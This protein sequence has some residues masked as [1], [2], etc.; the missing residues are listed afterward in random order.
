MR[1]TFGYTA[2]FLVRQRDVLI[3]SVACPI[4]L[5]AILYAVLGHVDETYTLDPV[6]LVVVED[7][8]FD[9]H[10]QFGAFVDALA[11]GD[12]ALLAPVAAASVDEARATMADGSFYGY[13]TLTADGTP[14]WFADS[15]HYGDPDD[16]APSVA[17]LILDRYVQQAGLAGAIAATNPAAFQDPAVLE[18]LAGGADLTQQVVVTANPPSDSVRY[19]YTLLGY[20]AFM[21]TYYALV[22]IT[23]TRA[24]QGSLGA[25]RT[26][27]GL[28]QV[29]TLVP[30]IGAAWLLSFVTTMADFFFIRVVLGVSFGGHELP[31][32]GVVLAASLVATCLGAITGALP[33]GVA[34]K[35]GMIAGLTQLMALF[36]GLFGPGSVALGDAIS[37]D[38]PWLA[39]INPIRQVNEACFNLYVFDDPS[40]LT[41]VFAKLGLTSLVLAV[42]AALLMRKQNYAHL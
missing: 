38:A 18:S 12:D 9:A 32:V 30:T 27:G 1:A 35:G 17:K 21:M 14:Q 20:G 41:P 11:D 34:A 15:R 16:P 28:N 7:A 2:R 42:G 3:W 40:L 31:L 33:M 6:K 36:A 10:P 22:A 8:N 13:V 19:F 37:R 4:V 5:T 25:R 23:A 29:Q 39:A 26:V 24:N